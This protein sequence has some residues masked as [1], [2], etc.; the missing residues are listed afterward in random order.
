MDFYSNNPYFYCIP[1]KNITDKFAIIQDICKFLQTDIISSLR[2]EEKPNHTKLDPKRMFLYVIDLILNVRKDIPRNESS[3][4][5]LLKTFFSNYYYYYYY[6]HYLHH[7]IEFHNTM[8]LLPITKNLNNKIF[9]TRYVTNK[10]RKQ[11]EKRKSKGNGLNQRT[12]IANEYARSRRNMKT[13]I[14]I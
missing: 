10:N 5:S 4:K 6:Y 11:N 3:Q 8:V 13:G 7:Q 2:F 1:L 9:L 12:S 14:R